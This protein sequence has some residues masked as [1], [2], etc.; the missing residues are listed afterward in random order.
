MRAA[1]SA[2]AI[3]LVNLSCSTEAPPGQAA[4]ASTATCDES[5]AVPGAAS[6]PIPDGLAPA[7]TF[8][9]DPDEPPAAL[10]ELAAALASEAEQAALAGVEC[11]EGTP[12]IAV[13][14]GSESL[15]AVD[16]VLN[17]S[18][19]F[20]VWCSCT[21]CEDEEVDRDGDGT[22]DCR[23]ECP[24]DADKVRPG[25][26]GC[27]AADQDTD[28]DGEIDCSDPCPGT[29]PPY[30]DRDGDGT[31]DC[32]DECPDEPTLTSFGAC[33]CET[34]GTGDSDADGTPDCNDDCPDDPAKTAGGTCGCGAT[35]EDGDGD[36]VPDCNDECSSDADKTAPGDC[37]CGVE[38]DADGDGVGDCAPVDW[39][40][41]DPCE[42]GPL[43]AECDPVTGELCAFDP[44]CCSVEWDATC[45]EEAR[46]LLASC[47][48]DCGDSVVDEDE[49]CDDGNTRSGD[50]CSPACTIERGGDAGP[51]TPDAGVDPADDAGPG[52]PDASPPPQDAGLPD[53]PP[54][55]APGPVH[56]AGPIRDAGPRDAGP[57]DASPPPGEGGPLPRRDQGL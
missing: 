2:I 23:D 49:E 31:P 37:G 5:V 50:G 56:D 22:P 35:E 44:F 17:Y 40:P 45:A 41:E 11:A 10:A 24:D 26:C 54:D 51:Y 57:R 28:E 3:L 42:P 32:S 53:P 55:A 9:L 46:L 16:C 13:A 15:S 43:V 14:P 4:R 25:E 21:S 29:S 33:D 48:S 39:C 19:D 12:V 1:P 34:S 30:T 8:Q 52:V 36:G 47:A 7:G 18:A 27:G 20:D 6:A 38:E